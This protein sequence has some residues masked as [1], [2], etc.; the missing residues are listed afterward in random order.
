MFNLLFCSQ[1]IGMK[2]LGSIVTEKKM[3]IW[4]F[5]RVG[6]LVKTLQEVR[7]LML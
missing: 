2:K 5:E 7:T 6:S 4:L 3:F 1:L